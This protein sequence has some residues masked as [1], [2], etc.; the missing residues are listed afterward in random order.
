MTSLH[1]G[2]RLR[3][4]EPFATCLASDHDTPRADQAQCIALDIALSATAKKLY[5][6]GR[7]LV[8]KVVVPASYRSRPLSSCSCEVAHDFDKS[9]VVESGTLQ[10][11]PTLH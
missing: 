1:Q 10:L 9:R 7:E 5:E 3:Q 4:H 11:P 6:E 2:A 8:W